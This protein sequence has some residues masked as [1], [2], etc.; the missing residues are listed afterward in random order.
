VIGAAVALQLL[1][2]LSGSAQAR[3]APRANADTGVIAGTVVT[4]EES[5]RPVRRAVVTLNA[6]DPLVGR[7]AITDD[8]GRFVFAHLPAARYTLAA[9]KRG[10]VGGLYGAKAIGR[11]GRG[12][13]L[14]PGERATPTIRMSPGGVITGTLL[15]QFGQPVSG[16]TLSVLK[17]AYSTSTGQ[18]RLVQTGA[19]YSGPDERGRYRIYGL[20]PGQYYMAAV[21]GTASTRAGGRDMHLT[22]DVDVQEALKAA[23]DG[24]AARITDAPQSNV[25][26]AQILYPGVTSVAQATP[27]AVRAGE[28]CSG[29]DFTIQY[30]TVAR[31]EGTILSPTG[32]PVATP[33]VFLVATDPGG[34]R[35]G[36]DETRYLE[37]GPDGRFAFAEVPPGAYMLSAHV[38]LPEVPGEV[39]RMLTGS[40]ELDV[41]SNVSGLSLTLQEGLTISGMMRYEGSGPAP[42][43]T[44]L[45]VTLVVTH[46]TGVPRMELGRPT[47]TADGRFTLPTVP[48]GR[49]RLGINTFSLLGPSWVMRSATLLG[50]DA[51][52]G[53][54][55]VR[56]SVTDAEIMVT[57]HLSELTGGIDR[58]AADYT[59]LLFSTN[60]VHW[61]P[62]SRRILNTRPATDGS[63]VFR[64]VPPGDY[65][66]VAADDVEPGE[67]YDPSFLQRLRPSAVTV[68]IAD[69][70][71]KV[72]DVKVGGG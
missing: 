72:Q 18:R 50:Q 65:H 35:S 11:P 5:P 21:N 40:S 49:Y 63:F 57:D 14:A 29:V 25:G 19:P 61:T 52:D 3:D 48:P 34:S 15:D 2:A 60:P 1:A 31:V 38:L 39:R 4:D 67:W 70:E 51:L 55:D 23:R 32:A 47:T 36:A 10:W 43:L 46:S 42:D 20:A 17:Y 44:S 66:L 13:P 37:A 30:S 62:L 69:G 33:V 24:P 71:K 58:G 56:Q 28:E 16:V 64:N 9:T 54:V 41:Q 22:S 26:Y 8:S 45:R 7:T 53:D 12:L 59:M 68:T 6:R 27:I